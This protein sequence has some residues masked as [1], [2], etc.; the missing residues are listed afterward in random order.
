MED[1]RNGIITGL[2]A[3]LLLAAIIALTAC[4]PV[5]LQYPATTVRGELLQ[6]HYGTN[7]AQYAPL[8]VR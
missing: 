3:L 8:I 2:A 5:P 4:A 7:R 1:I 6:N